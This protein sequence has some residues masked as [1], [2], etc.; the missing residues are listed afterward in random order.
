V[1]ELTPKQE[2]FA[3][4]VVETGNQSEAYRRSYNVDPNCRPETIWTEACL[5]MATPKVSQRVFQL[6]Q[7][8]KER[9]LVTVE[10]I[11]KELEQVREAAFNVG[12]FAP[13]NTAIMGKAKIHGLLVDKQESKQ[14]VTIKTGASDKIKDMI[15]EIAKRTTSDT[16]S[17]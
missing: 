5:L 1:D 3:R 11:T 17:N 14:E 8:A 2:A 12:E 7:E 6:Q 9:T 13:A 16:E 10:S 15:N 4:A